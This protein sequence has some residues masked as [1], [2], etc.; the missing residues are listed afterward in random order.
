MLPDLALASIV[1]RA[2]RTRDDLMAARGLDG[3]HVRDSTGSAILAAVEAGLALPASELRIPETDSTDRTLAPAVT[4]IGAWL[5]QRASELG[6]EPSLLATR[7]DIS[8]FVSHGTGRLATG[9]RREIV[10]EP[11]RRLIA[12]EAAIGL[13]NGGRRIALTSRD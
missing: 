5:A 12:G 10:G 1:Q 11:I 7:N 3:R 13:D 9:W 2:P 6:L 4:V 8:V